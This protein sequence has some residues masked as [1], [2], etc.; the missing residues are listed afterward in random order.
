VTKACPDGIGITP[1]VEI[2]D[3]PATEENEPLQKAI[4]ILKGKI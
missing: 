3:D 4:E 1:D 2:E